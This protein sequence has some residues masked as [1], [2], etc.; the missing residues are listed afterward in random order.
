MGARKSNNQLARDLEHGKT[1]TAQCYSELLD[2]FDAE[3]KT[4]FHQDHAPDHKAFKTMTK[5]TEFPIP[6]ILPI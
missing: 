2:Q 1:T 4:L 3:S 5:L 6:H